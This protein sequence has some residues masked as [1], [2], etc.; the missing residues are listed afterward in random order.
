[1]LPKN[2]KSRIPN[3]IF[4]NCLIYLL[5]NITKHSPQKVENFCF[6]KD[7]LHTWWPHLCISPCNKILLEFFYYYPIICGRLCLNW[8]SRGGCPHFICAHHAGC[9]FFK[10]VH[11]YLGSKRR[12]GDARVLYFKLTNSPRRLIF[13]LT[14]SSCKE[15]FSN[16]STL[17]LGMHFAQI[18]FESS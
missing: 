1:M 16:K 3:I 12:W 8:G 15:V 2:S 5:I 14:N 11:G 4:Q 17:C 7:S 6:P 9:P 10:F 18:L 13:R